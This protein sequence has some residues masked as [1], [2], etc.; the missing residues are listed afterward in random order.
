MTFVEFNFGAETDVDDVA[1]AAADV[2]PVA[3]LPE[4]EAGIFV[5]LP[6]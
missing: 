5:A 1:A 2:F 6:V 3:L 4:P